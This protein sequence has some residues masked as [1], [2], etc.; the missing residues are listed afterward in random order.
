MRLFSGFIKVLFF[1][2]LTS[3][4]SLAPGMHLKYGNRGGQRYV[5]AKG[6]CGLPIIEI[7]ACLIEHLRCERAAQMGIY[8]SSFIDGESCEYRI[9]TG[10]KIA[11]FVWGQ[12]DFNNPASPELFDMPVKHTVDCDG[13]IFF[14]YVGE[15][16]AS[17]KTQSELRRDVSDGLEPMVKSPQVSVSVEEF[18]S[19]YVN[20]MGEVL[21]PNVIPVTD[22]PMTPL[23]AVSRAGGASPFGDLKHILLKREG[24][25]LEI[26]AVPGLAATSGKLP[27]LR[28]GDVVYVP[29][30]V[31]Q[32]VYVLG[33]VI[34]P[35]AVT[36]D[37]DELTL[38]Q[39][40]ARAA[41]VEPFAS[42]PSELFVFRV[43][44]NGDRV[45]YHLDAKSPA[46]LV[47][48]NEFVLK[49][50]DIIYVGTYQPAKLNRIMTNFL[51]SS[52]VIAD[53]SRA[54]RDID[55]VANDRFYSNDDD[56]DL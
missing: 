53:L 37:C 41:G 19:Q 55:E 4:S 21:K 25:V 13:T 48:A 6:M 30:R 52:R 49:R 42:K 33:E 18:R 47:L 1:V 22:V 31:N 39:A 34:F 46:A 44:D 23:D 8:P 10:D 5:L 12:P 51:S 9:G 56:D 27:V 40:L 26:N 36:I 50:Q 16:T 7:D 43:E 45:A 14:P 54:V 20:V 35:Q 2:V 29:P 38:S 15:I 28:H 3:C 17:G 32:Q 24:A 11:I